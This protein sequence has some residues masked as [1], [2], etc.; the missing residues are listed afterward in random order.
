MLTL[1]DIHAGY[2]PNRVLH[3]LSARIRPG[4]LT[5]LVG[6]NG[7]GKSTLLKA[8]MGFVP[9]A[10]G[11]ILLQGQDIGRFG[12]R[13]LARRVAWMPQE[14]SCPDGLTVGGLVELAGHA[15]RSLLGGP[16]E[17]DRQRY[18]QTLE[19]VGLDA[20]RGSAVNTL[21]G[22]QR[23]RA[24]IAMTL[25]QDTPLILMDEPVN[26]LDLKYQ[27]DTLKL[28]RS[29][30][31]DHGRTVLMILHDLNL[32]AA[33]ADEILM[34][35]EGRLRVAGPPADTITQAHVSAVFGLE[36]EIFEHHGRRVCLPPAD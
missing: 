34:L 5:A 28:V 32:A 25:A 20:H 26:H 14:C 15:R 31:R 12:R 3:G 16:S 22:G 30:V 24:W 18:R 2:G 23:Q 4:A 1:Q 33:F 35:A 6:P 8:I 27:Y 13:Q 7:C 17:A 11:R 19:I 10:Q 9:L 29:L 36:A 21:S